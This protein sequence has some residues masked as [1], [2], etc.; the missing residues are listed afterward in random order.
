MNLVKKVKTASVARVVILEPLFVKQL[1]NRNKV[2]RCKF[3]YFQP[4][5]VGIILYCLEP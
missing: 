2:K 1:N 4:G 5:R 3:K